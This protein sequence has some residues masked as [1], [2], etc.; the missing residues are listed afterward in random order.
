MRVIVDSSKKYQKT[1]GFGG[2]FTDSAGF[3]IASLPK[4]A[5][6]K[7]MSAYFGEHGM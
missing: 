3:N 6:E 7:L 4:L 2:A 5:Q 1:V